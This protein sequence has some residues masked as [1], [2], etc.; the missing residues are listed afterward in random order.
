MHDQITQFSKLTKE[1]NLSCIFAVIGEEIVILN[2]RYT[3]KANWKKKIK[4]VFQKLQ[5]Q[6]KLYKYSIGLATRLRTLKILS[7]R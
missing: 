1:M 6:N 5:T 2:S 3:D 7:N 4:K